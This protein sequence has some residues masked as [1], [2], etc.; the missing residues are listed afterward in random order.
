MFETCPTNQ[1]Y[2]TIFEIELLDHHI[3][4]SLVV[5]NF[6]VCSGCSLFIAYYIAHVH[7]FPSEMFKL[8]EQQTL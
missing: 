8:P 4:L 7:S 1:K 3:M 6:H 5:S 2:K